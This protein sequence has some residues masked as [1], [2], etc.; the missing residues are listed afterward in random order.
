MN[1]SEARYAKHLEWRRQRGEI[2]AFWYESVKFRLADKTWYTPDFKVMK[3]DGQIELHEL[4]G[5]MQDDAAVKLK[6]ASEAYWIYP[7][8]LVREKPT[9]VFT[10]KEVGR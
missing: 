10:L 8:I 3:A 4:K 9:N 7:V 1:Q 2:A 6:V 5:W